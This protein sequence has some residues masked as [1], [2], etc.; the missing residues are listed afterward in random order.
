MAKTILKILFSFLLFIN[1]LLIPQ[2]VLAQSIVI[3][4]FMAKPDDNIEW[5]ELYNP[6][7]QIVDLTGW[8]LKDGNSSTTDDL[9]LSGQISALG[10][11]T[12]DHDKGWL[13]DTGTETIT[14]LDQNSNAIDSYSYSGATSG[15]TYGRQPDGE[16][17]QSN[18]IATK[19]STNGGA[20]PSPSPSSSP[21]STFTISGVP[22]EMNSTQ[23]FTTSVNL[24]LSSYP[25]TKFYL[26]GAFAKPDSTNYFGYTKVSGNWVKNNNKYSD[27]YELSTDSSGKWAGNLEVQIDALDS[28]YTGTDDYI[29]KVGRYTETGNGPT[30]SNVINIKI[31]AKEIEAEGGV[32]NLSGLTAKQPESVLGE[33][34]KVSDIPDEVYSLENYRRGATNSSTPLPQIDKTN[35]SKQ[36]LFLP[37]AGII[38]L[39]IGLGFGGYKIYKNRVKS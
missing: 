19:G 4:E 3:N 24:E 15:K 12:F 11:I 26:K 27:Q 18:L 35:K 13:N 36:N 17:W 37:I 34:Q 7:N 1:V 38:F 25:N 21:I 2:I 30:W 22:S 16:S 20:S 31:N 23:T 14:L 33:S 32:M 9:T 6:T 39:G 5:I 29:F 28:G 8:K 10:F